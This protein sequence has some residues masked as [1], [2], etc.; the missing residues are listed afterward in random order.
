MATEYRK[1]Y[2]DPDY[3]K[4][5]YAR[6][7]AE[8]PNFLKHRNEATRSATEMKNQALEDMMTCVLEEAMEVMNAEELVR[9]LWA[10]VARNKKMGLV[11]ELQERINAN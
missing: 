10:N 8:D 4:N 2:K 9:L 7:K 1:R 11:K 6:R 3:Y 5:Y